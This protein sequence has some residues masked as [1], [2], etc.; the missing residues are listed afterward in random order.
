MTKDIEGNDIKNKLAYAIGSGRIYFIKGNGQKVDVTK[1][2]YACI[3][4]MFEALEEQ[5]EE[6]LTISTTNLKTKEVNKLK[7]ERMKLK[8][9]EETK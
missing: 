3:F 1:S 5:G 4:H 8:E 2:F 7:I 9:V 6:W